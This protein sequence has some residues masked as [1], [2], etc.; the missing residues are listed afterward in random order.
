MRRPLLRLALLLFYE[1]AGFRYAMG[2][3]SVRMEDGVH[4]R[5]AL[6]RAALGFVTDHDALGREVKKTLAEPGQAVSPG[7]WRDGHC[8]K[9]RL[10]QIAQGSGGQGI[11]LAIERA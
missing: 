10:G 5:A 11:A 3:M 2:C 7:L 4:P 8:G 1:R 9:R 6:V